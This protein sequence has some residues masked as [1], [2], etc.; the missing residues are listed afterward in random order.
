LHGLNSLTLVGCLRWFSMAGVLGW[1]CTPPRKGEPHPSKKMVPAWNSTNSEP[2]KVIKP[3]QACWSTHVQVRN[4]ISQAD[5]KQ[6]FNSCVDAPQGRK[7][8]AFKFAEYYPIW[9]PLLIDHSG[10]VQSGG[11]RAYKMNIHHKCATLS[12]RD[13]RGVLEMPRLSSGRDHS[14]MRTR[15]PGPPRSREW[16]VQ[17]SN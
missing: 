17:A 5:A 7:Y 16:V 2:S 11:D 8:R 13:A 12:H 3:R 10:Y 9:S 14:P 4:F 6:T 1:V 15:R